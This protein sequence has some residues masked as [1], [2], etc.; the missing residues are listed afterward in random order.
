MRRTPRARTVQALRPA[1][2]ADDLAEPAAELYD[3]SR[4]VF[5]QNVH[6]LGDRLGSNPTLD[7]RL[8][9]GS[10]RRMAAPAPLHAGGRHGRVRPGVE[11]GEH[12][13]TSTSDR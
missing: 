11:R 2:T 12:H 6:D 5:L 9:A 10:Q 7:R 13:D 8:A 4:L 3:P 1:A